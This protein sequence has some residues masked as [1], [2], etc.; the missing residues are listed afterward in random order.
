M[1]RG[2]GAHRGNSHITIMD[3]NGDAVAALVQD[4]LVGR[5]LWQ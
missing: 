4:W 5:G 3:R 1:D 2:H